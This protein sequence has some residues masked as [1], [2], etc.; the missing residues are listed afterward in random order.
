M[1]TSTPVTQLDRRTFLALT[2][3]GVSACASA[4]RA[5]SE[6]RCDF[7]LLLRGGRVFDGTGGP[8]WSADLGLRGDTLVAVGTL[9]PERS[10]RTFELRGLCVAP[11][12]IDIHTHSDADVFAYPGDES[13]LLQGITTEITGNCGG[14]AAP[15]DPATS[16]EDDAELAAD[17]IHARWTDVASYRRALEELRPATNQGLLIGQGT[18]RTHVARLENRALT[19]AELA[20]VQRELEIGLEQGALGLSSGLEYVPGRYTPTDELI[21]LCR[22]VARHGKLYASHV[23]NE[24]A[25]LVEAIDEALRIGRESGVRT[26]ISHLKAAGKPNWSKQDAT[27]AQIETARAAGV[28]VLA[29][30]YPYTAYSTGLT[31]FLSDAAR[32]GGAD[33][34]VARLRDPA[35]RA[36]I[37]GELLPRVASDPGGFELIVIASVGRGVNKSSIGQDL[38]AIGKQRG[39]EPVDALLALLEEEHADVGFVGHA[40]SEENVTRVLCHPLVMIGSDGRALAPRGRALETQPHPRSYGAFARVLARY[41]RELRVLDL[42]SAV[43]KM[44]SMPATQLGLA[45]RGRIAPGM[46][47][48]LVVFDPALVKDEASFD[49]PHRTASGFVHVFVNGV[50]AVEDGRC[51]GARPGRVL[52]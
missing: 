28:E 17:G 46:K 2:A 22:V 40:M 15:R 10:A 20:R 25:E 31:I 33:A 38:A 5:R 6:R 26:Q 37:R 43:K 19:A 48:D 27:L 8:E 51:T 47:A 4:P 24:E 11:G 12:F 52:G 9:D 36:R 16:A 39:I 50:A 14:S 1:E 44:T 34:I 7:D 42:A 29:D 49:T 32:V 45:D 41:V 30:A 18:L 21:A 23:R 3:A 35:Q 13:R